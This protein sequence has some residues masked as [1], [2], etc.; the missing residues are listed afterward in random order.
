MLERVLLA[1][2]QH[3]F[4]LRETAEALGIHPNTLRY[5]L[6]RA[7]DILHADFEDPET[8]FRLQLAVRILDFANNN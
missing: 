2:A 4:H 5:R 1:F 3:G 8:R 7:V 6:A